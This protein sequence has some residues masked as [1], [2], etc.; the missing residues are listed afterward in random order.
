VRLDVLYGTAPP[1]TPTSS[2][3]LS[4]HGVAFRSS[5]VYT[6]GTPLEVQVLVDSA[7]REAG[8]FCAHGKV[9]RCVPGIVAVEFT[10]FSAQDAG[11]LDALFM[12]LGPSPVRG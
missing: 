3:D 11:K 6:V 1:L 12:R 8:W 9:A 7:H 5:Q 4:N 10:K 2:V